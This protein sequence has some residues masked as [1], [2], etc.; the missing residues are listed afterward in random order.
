MTLP[1][2]VII[3]LGLLAPPSQQPVP[4]EQQAPPPA[5]IK[6]GEVTGD[7]V[8]LRSGPGVNYYPVARLQKGDRV[9]IVGH[10]PAWVGVAP[11]S[12]T[13][14]LVAKQYVDLHGKGRGVINGDRVWVRAGTE[15]SDDKYAKQTRLSK[16]ARVTI[17]GESGE[18]HKIVPPKGAM[19][20]ISADYVRVMEE[21]QPAIAE[22][23][24]VIEATP[25]VPQA[26]PPPAPSI[27]GIETDRLQSRIERLE[28]I[29]KQEFKKDPYHRDLQGVVD[30]F[31]PLADQDEDVAAKQYAAYRIKQLQEAMSRIESQKKAE[32]LTVRLREQRIQFLEE[33]S[34]I[35]PG[36]V[37]L[38]RE[39]DVRGKFVTSAAYSS[40]V[41]LQRF[42]IIDPD[43]TGSIPH[44]LAYIEIDPQANIDPQAFVGRYVGV[45]ARG[46]RL[47][48]GSV[49]PM[50][51]Y[52]AAE[53][54]I[55]EEVPQDEQQ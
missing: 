18:F 51:V 48:E 26:T 36:P 42:R 46:R 8:H 54:V 10:K 24:P 11:P 32:E 28:Q 6:I 15:L 22:Q 47:L 1:T 19:L 31:A 12:N 35:H 7:E 50:V 20:W 3:V 9:V 25:A 4:A 14:S 30:R 45:R 53:I 23:E 5:S 52:T 43:H 34:R 2:L 33:R 49:D 37:H 40:P 17:V 41:G 39:F 29:L 44:T 27:E 38:A 21:S 13:Y 55:L 16:G